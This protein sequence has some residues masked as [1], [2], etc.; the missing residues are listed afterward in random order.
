MLTKKCGLMLLA[1][2]LVVGIQAIAT[3]DYIT[4]VT[5]TASSEEIGV[6]NFDRVAANLVSDNGFNVNGP[7]TVDMNP[8]GDWNTMGDGVMWQSADRASIPGYNVIAE[9]WLEFD[10]GATYSLASMKVWNYNGDPGT[11]YTHRGVK[12]MIV[13]VS[14]DR[15]NWTSLGTTTL[16]ESPHS[17]TVDFGQ[18]IS[19]AGANNV[20]YVLFDIET[21]INSDSDYVV[22]LSKVRFAA[23]P[24][25]ATWLLLLVGGMALVAH[26]GLGRHGRK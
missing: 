14:A 13:K 18:T 21:A 24:E 15:A 5:A 6:I 19:L 1:A 25:P 26:Q 10:L 16:T 11:S 7:G 23:V 12:D 17:D 2:V 20:R 22:G 8:D 4:G 3:A 9:Q